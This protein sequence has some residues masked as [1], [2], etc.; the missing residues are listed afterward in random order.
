MDHLNA[1]LAAKPLTNAPLETE[2]GPFLLN[3]SEGERDGLFYIPRNAKGPF[4]LLVLLHGAGGKA[5]QMLVPFRDIADITKTALLV[6]ESRSQTWDIIEGAY[7]PDIKFI[8]HSLNKLFNLVL[9]DSNR[10]AIGGFSDG[11]SYALSVGVTNGDFFSHI[12]A[13]SPGFMAPPLRRD[14]PHI[15]ISHGTEDRVLSINS[16]SRKLVPILEKSGMDVVYREFRG[17]HT[18]PPDLIKEGFE[19]FL[20]PSPKTHEEIRKARAPVYENEIKRT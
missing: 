5:S 12:M 9:I 16:C 18:M 3:L 2:A 20:H 15:F 14:S 11:A 4:P 17:G 6:P 10:M 8:D 1:T 13:F 19:W 7:G